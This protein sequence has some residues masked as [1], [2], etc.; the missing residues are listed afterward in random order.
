MRP[1]FS[2]KLLKNNIV[3]GLCALLCCL[4]WGSAFPGVKIGYRYFGITN[5]QPGTQILFAG[6]RFVIA[7]VIILFILSFK[8]KK[9]LIPHWYSFYHSII[10]SLFQTVGQYIFFYIGLAHSTGVKS[11]IVVAS[12]VFI[13]V[14]LS[15]IIFKQEKLNIQK[16]IGTIVGFSG[17]IIIN[18]YGNNLDYG[19]TLT[20]E[21][22]ILISAI[23]YSIA[24]V[25]LKKYSN[26]ENIPLISGYQFLIGGII[27]CFIGYISGGRIH[28]ITRDGMLILLYLAFVSAIAY[29]LWSLM[30]KYNNISK[31]AV[32]GFMNPIFGVIL[33]ALFLNEKSVASGGMTIIALL[34]VS[35]G[36]FSV[37]YEKK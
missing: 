6:F 20:G 24:S 16:M 26:H 19:F 21:G 15:S 23:L 2:K 27:M 3:I 18:C 36:I 12:N 32:Y 8:E 35:I 28:T 30:I 11:S 5:S 14:I 22:F 7:G 37:N 1:E 9:V 10:I 29:T 13:S 34:L 31:I 25:L 4:L 33:S 17:V